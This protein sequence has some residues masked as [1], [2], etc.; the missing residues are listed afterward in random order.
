MLHKRY[1][2]EFK[3]KAVKQVIECGGQGHA[4]LANENVKTVRSLKCP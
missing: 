2:S 3:E 1:T 4:V